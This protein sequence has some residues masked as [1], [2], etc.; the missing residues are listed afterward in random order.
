M[1]NILID[2]KGQR[3]G[4]FLVLEFAYIKNGRGCWKCQCDCG[5]IRIVAGTCLRNGMSKS[6]GCYARENSSIR[7]SGSSHPM[8]GKK[9]PEH[10]E[11]MRGSKHPKYNAN[12]TKEERYLHRRYFEYNKWRKSVFERDNYTCQYCGTKRSPFN[13]HHLNGHDKFIELRTEI[14]NGIT[15]C[16]IC[17]KEFHRLYGR[18]NNTEMQFTNFINKKGDSCMIITDINFKPFFKHIKSIFSNHFSVKEVKIL[19]EFVLVLAEA[20]FKCYIANMEVIAHRK[21]KDITKDFKLIADLEWVAR[22]VGEY[23]VA[24]KANINRYISNVKTVKEVVP[25]TGWITDDIVY[26]IGEMM[27][28]LSIETIKR[29]DFRVNNR[30]QHMTQSTLNLSNRVESY[31]KAKLAEIDAKGFYECVHEQRTYDLEEIVEELVI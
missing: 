28:R 16:E 14:T 8:F 25:P 31:L 30:P 13:A 1:K 21:N 5:E 22:S 7:N 10:S 12:L 6:C 9:R 15:L 18:G 24:S 20:N 19:M 27:D 4:R 2:I 26:S 29:E 3:F 11:K 17:H 23:R